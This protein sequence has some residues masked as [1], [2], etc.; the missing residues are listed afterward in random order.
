ML[1]LESTC[2]VEVSFNSKIITAICSL[3]VQYHSEVMLQSLMCA[4]IQAT[5]RHDAQLEYIT[6]EGTWLLEQPPE[7]TH[8]LL[9]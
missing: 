2:Q 6:C 8:L 1:E 5:T 9:L 3:H 4:Q 7:G